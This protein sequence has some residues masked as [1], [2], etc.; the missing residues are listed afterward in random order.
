MQV[1]HVRMV[2][3][4]TQPKYRVLLCYVFFPCVTLLR[5]LISL[6]VAELPA[7]RACTGGWQ[8]HLPQGHALVEYVCSSVAA[9][10]APVSI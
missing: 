10:G 9:P 5:T 1:K 7:G 3:R 6:A 2:G 4:G 8:G